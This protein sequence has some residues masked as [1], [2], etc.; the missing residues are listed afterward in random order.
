MDE[1]CADTDSFSRANR[2]QDGVGEQISGDTPALPALIDCKPAEQYD[3]CRI[4][5]VASDL[6]SCDRVQ[7]GTNGETVMSNDARTGAGDECP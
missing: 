2:A 4:R 7:C 3:G 1:H 6:A 5:H